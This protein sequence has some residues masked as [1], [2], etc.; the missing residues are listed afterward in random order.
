[1]LSMNSSTKF[2][3]PRLFHIFKQGY[4]LEK[5]RHDFFAGLTVAIVAFP[6][7][8]ALAVASGTTPEKGL[9][10]AIVAGFL[11]SALGGSRTQIGGPTGAF[12]VIVFEIIQTH[13][14]SG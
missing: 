12:V 4:S 11:I 2:F 6:L 3:G 9:V 14:F 7:A 1:M 8:M 5:F 13:G 10:T